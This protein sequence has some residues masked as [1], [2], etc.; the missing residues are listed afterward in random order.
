M[1]TPRSLSAFS[2]WVRF[3]A[4]ATGVRAAAP[5]EVF[6]AA[7]VRPTERRCGTITP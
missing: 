1:N 6:H 7:A 4:M 3:D 5:A 2:V